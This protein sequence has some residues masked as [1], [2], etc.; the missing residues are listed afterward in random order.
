MVLRSDLTPAMEDYLKATYLQRERHGEV[1]VLALAQAL[2]VASPSV[3][4]MIKRLA[5]LGLLC[6]E[7]YGGIALTPAGE[8]VA[9]E[10]IRHHRLLEL[11]LTEALGMSWEEVHAEA[12]RL[13]HHI[14]EALEERI[15]ERLG[16]PEHDPHGDPIPA[17][18][19]TLPTTYMVPLSELAPGAVGTVARIADQQPGLLHYVST[20]GLVPGATVRVIAV[21]PYGGVITV[22]VGQA[23]AATHAI[24]GEVAAHIL[25]TPLESPL[26]T[27]PSSLVDPLAAVSIEGAL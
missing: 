25:V 17:R 26:H 1:T 16:Q 7:R 5:G 19:L 4:G 15:A 24:G 9:L 14:S 18:D 12:D 21:A 27:P 10:T 6:H 3:T 20:L 2:E 22:A 8:A 13:E 23:G 11:Y